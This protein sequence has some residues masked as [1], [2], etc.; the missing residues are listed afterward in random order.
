[1]SE[2]KIPDIFHNDPYAV[3]EEPQAERPR[4][5]YF[6]KEISMTLEEV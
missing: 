4:C 3:N 6:D 2:K 1:M 5:L